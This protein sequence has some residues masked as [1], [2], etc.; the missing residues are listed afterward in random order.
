MSIR[1]YGGMVLVEREEAE[2]FVAGGILVIPDSAK[3][4]PCR[5][6]VLAVGGGR[7]EEDGVFRTPQVEPGQRVLWDRMGAHEVPGEPKLRL[8][9]SSY[10]LAVLGEKEA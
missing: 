1:P 8:V 9:S 4:I 7:V 2:Q 6:R 10:V 3:K 5:G